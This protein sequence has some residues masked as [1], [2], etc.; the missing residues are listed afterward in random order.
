VMTILSSLF[1]N[2][3]QMSSQDITL[4]AQNHIS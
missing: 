2:R 3:L 4:N 1:E